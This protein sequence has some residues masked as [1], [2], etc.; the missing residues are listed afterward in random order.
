[1]E[2]KRSDA[3][4]TGAFALVLQVSRFAG[5]APLR[6]VKQRGGWRVSLSSS[7]SVYGCVLVTVMSKYL[8]YVNMYYHHQPVD[9]G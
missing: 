9:A 7:F 8:D 6:F 4:V 5:I 2:A 1:M 3:F